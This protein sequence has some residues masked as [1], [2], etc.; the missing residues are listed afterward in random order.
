MKNIAKFA[1]ALAAALLL[2]I[3]VS[4]AGV[5]AADLVEL[6]AD[7]TGLVLIPE[8]G[9]LF[10]LEGMMPGD[11]ATATIEIRNSYNRTFVL[12]MRAE[13]PEDSD[14]SLLQQLKLTVVPGGRVQ[15][16]G[17]GEGPLGEFGE[18]TITIGTFRPGDTGELVATV[19]LPGPETG[20]EYQDKTAGIKW[21]F[22]AQVRRGGG[23][24][25]GGD[26]DD[27]DDYWYD[28]RPEPP[29]VYP[30]KELVIKPEPPGVMPKTGVEA[31]YL[32]YVLGGLALFGGIQLARRPRRK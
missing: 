9:K 7:D 23:G 12:Y 10:E 4:P 29:K 31:P 14:P 8:D 21:V 13:D 30:E 18:N 2:M 28:Y 24:G 26:D 27:D 16:A 15:Y 25:G 32:Y 11:T 5:R 6:I 3:A 1:A 19:R 20:N 22:T 17:Y